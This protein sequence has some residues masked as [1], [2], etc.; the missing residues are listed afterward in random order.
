VVHLHLLNDPAPGTEYSAR[1]FPF[2]IGRAPGSDLRLTA[3]GVFDHHAELRLHQDRELV[4]TAQGEATML[5]NGHSVTQSVLRNGDLIDLGG[6]R[7]RFSLAPPIPR[8][9]QLRE[10]LTWISL[11]ALF[12]AQAALIYWLLN[13]GSGAVQ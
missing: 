6:A 3:A 8:G 4:L 7:L 9:L 12:L 10:T 5:V 11:G 1:R 2:R 13:A